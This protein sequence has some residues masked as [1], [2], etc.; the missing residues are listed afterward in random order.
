MIIA[1]ARDDEENTAVTI[2]VSVTN[3]RRFDMIVKIVAECL[4]V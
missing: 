1:E 3:L 4:N 2:S